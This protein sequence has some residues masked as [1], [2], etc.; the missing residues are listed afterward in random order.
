MA[1]SALGL[2]GTQEFGTATDTTLA[3]GAEGSSGSFWDSFGNIV[4]DLGS[5]ASGIGTTVTLAEQGRPSSV[6]VGG[7][8]VPATSLGSA[9]TSL[10]ISGSTMGL[11]LIGLVVLVLVGVV[12][13]AAKK[14]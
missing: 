14:R 1:T 4:N 7:T 5:L 3:S 12:V 9:A 10:G 8:A 2:S 11:V 6:A 13:M